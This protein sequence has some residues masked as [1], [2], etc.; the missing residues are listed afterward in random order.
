MGL[1]ITDICKTFNARPPSAAAGG[2]ETTF[3]VFILNFIQIKRVPQCSGEEEQKQLA[4]AAAIKSVIFSR[5][6]RVSILFLH[7]HY[8]REL[9]SG[10]IQDGNRAERDEKHCRKWKI[11]L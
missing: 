5:L 4:A 2:E 6:Q 7:A 10:M 8:L 11:C 9:L 1:T 3:R